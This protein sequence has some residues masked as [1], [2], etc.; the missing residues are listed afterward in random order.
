MSA[1]LRKPAT[2]RTGETSG[3]RNATPV[4]SGW[5]GLAFLAALL[6][7][8]SAQAQMTGG[9][10]GPFPGGERPA[11]PEYQ[12]PAPEE[13]LVLPPLPEAAPEA[14]APDITSAPHVQVKQYR[15]VGNAVFSDETLAEVAAPYAGRNVT[16]EELQELRHKLTLYY[17]DRG[18]INSGAV[19]PDQKVVEGVIAFVI[20]EGTLSDISIEGNKRLRTPYI[21]NRLAL[22]A[23]PP[24][25]INDLQEK[26]QLLHQNP[27]IRRINAELG[28]GV[29]RGEATLKAGVEEARAWELGL[30]FANNRSPSVG[31]ERLELFAAHNNLLGW[32][33]AL[34]ARYGLTEG[35]DDVS[36]YYAV[37]L[38]AYDTTLKVQYDRSDAVVVEAPFDE[39]DIESE[40]ETWGVTLSHPILK[41]PGAEFTLALAGERRSSKTWLLGDPYS[42]SEG[43]ED[44][45]SDVT[46]VRFS[47]YWLTRG[48]NRVFAVRSVF[49]LGLDAMGATINDSGVD[50]RF[51]AWLGQIQWARR[52]PF[53]KNAQVIFRTD[54]QFSDSPLLP[55]EK[56]S[57]GGASS[58]RG[59][60][61][62]QIVRDNA[63]V[64]SAELRIP[65]FRL[66]LPKISRN[67]EDGMVQLAPF[68]DWGWA[69][70]KNRT[71]PDPKTVSSIGLGLRWD[72]SPNIHAHVYWG[73]PFED[74]DNPEDDLQDEGVHFQ[75]R[76]QFF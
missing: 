32:G 45:E 48:R 43:V 54:L 76:W 39:I 25:N 38:N 17:I 23:G 26:F 34:G 11:L 5:I 67:P 8:A 44:G 10:E 31:G 22:G 16:F 50:G 65:V 13:D 6:T 66:P 3:R 15:F 18:Y 59:Y 21:R 46:V 74:I 36:A 69:E 9:R 28:P 63:A 60:R 75:F 71:T 49:T 35:L 4:R 56:F 30:Q 57:V 73:Y 42:F 53:V 62:N 51:F 72:P 52:L 1:F 61:E 27:L 24:L 68:I 20:V 41:T 12:T 47:Q 70:N 14:A 64:S 7:A 33:D 19:I 40:S 37:P 2:R 58:V 29:R 55:L